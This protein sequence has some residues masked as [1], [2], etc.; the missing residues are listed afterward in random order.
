VIRLKKIVIKL[1]KIVDFKDIESAL[2]TLKKFLE[3]RPNNV[4]N[5]QEYPSTSKTSM[6]LVYGRILS[7]YYKFFFPTVA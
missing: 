1:E 6:I 4:I 2:D 7:N 5:H 3:Q